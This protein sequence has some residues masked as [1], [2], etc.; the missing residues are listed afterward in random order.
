MPR[1]ASERRCGYSSATTLLLHCALK[2]SVKNIIMPTTSQLDS[3]RP[4]IIVTSLLIALLLSLSRLLL[5]T[6]CSL[7]FG[8]RSSSSTFFVTTTAT[9]DAE[10]LS[11]YLDYPIQA[12]PEGVV[13]DFVNPSSI[14][15]QLY[16]TAGVCIPLMLLFSLTRLLSKV[17]VGPKK[18]KTDESRSP[19]DPQLCVI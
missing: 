1:A 10:T 8:S 18:I 14:S 6:R 9:M 2:G 5:I 19:Q 17:Y 15:Y 16:I 4:R 7:L 11:H 13:P 3:F 12:P